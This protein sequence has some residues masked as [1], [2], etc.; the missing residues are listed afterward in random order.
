LTVEVLSVNVGSVRTV[1]HD[2]KDVVTGI[3]KAPV[4]GRIA[5]RGVNL[6][7]DDQA[8][9]MVHGGPDR[10]LYAYAEEDYAWWERE[11]ERQ[12]APGTFGENLTTRGI[13]L[14]AA[15][16]GERWRIGSALLQ[17]TTPRFPCYK[18]AM[19]MGDPAFV[20]RFGQAERE[21][22]YLAIV[23]EGEL[24]RGDAIEVEHRPAHD[25]TIGKMTHIY[26]FER[27]RLSELLVPELPEEWRQWIVS[28]PPT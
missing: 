4:D 15:L 6:D 18:L 10:A 20:K 13:D 23:E 7:G 9:R 1:R 26:L 19:K 21:G 2:G 16:V 14:N 5:V 25:L 22:S 11:L 8:D 27:S 12:L 24:G 28:R 17:I 3:F